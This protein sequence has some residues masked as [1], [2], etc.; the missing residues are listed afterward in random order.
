MELTA[1]YTLYNDP[2]HPYTQALVSAVPITDP[3]V[4][5]KR[6]RIILEGDVPSPA[7]PPKGCN[8]S[9]RCPVAIDTCFEVE[10]ELK[11]PASVPG[12]IKGLHGVACHLVK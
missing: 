9:T 11:E 12:V 4:E 1:R 10:P 7:N 5:E 2:K 3:F 8:F 6:Q